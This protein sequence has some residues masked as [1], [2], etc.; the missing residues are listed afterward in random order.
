MKDEALDKIKKAHKSGDL[1]AKDNALDAFNKVLKEITEVPAHER[2]R[3]VLRKW[4]NF[5]GK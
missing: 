5:I 2:K 3:I 4:Q 1:S